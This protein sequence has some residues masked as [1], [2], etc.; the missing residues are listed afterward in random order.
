MLSLFK[1]SLK[2]PC[3]VLESEV[4]VRNGL[5]EFTVCVIKLF[6]GVFLVFWVLDKESC[7][8][9]CG[10]GYGLELANGLC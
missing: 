9:V 8:S 2:R 7:W 10:L 6:L 3:S 1:L 4:K 5:R